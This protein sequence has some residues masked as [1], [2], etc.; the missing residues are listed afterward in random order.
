[1]NNNNN[2]NNTAPEGIRGI[3]LG[4]NPEVMGVVTSGACLG[5]MF[6]RSDM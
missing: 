4:T 2:V 1:M 3:L 5:Q 6:S